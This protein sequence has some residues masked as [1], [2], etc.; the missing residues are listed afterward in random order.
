MRTTLPPALQLHA[1]TINR[2]QIERRTRAAALPGELFR[3]P[4]W[5]MLLDLAAHAAHN[6]RLS[7]TGIAQTAGLPQTTG[8]RHLEALREAGLVERHPD[9]YDARRTWVSLTPAGQDAMTAYLAA[10]AQGGVQ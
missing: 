7:V 3:E 1:A 4:C 6:R 8:L 10:I 2:L 5:D 9:A